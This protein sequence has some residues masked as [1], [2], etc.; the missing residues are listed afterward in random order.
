[1]AH[2]PII[3]IID[4]SIGSHKITNTIA[5]KD[6]VGD[7]LIAEGSHIGR[8]FFKNCYAT[9]IN[10]WEDLTTIPVAATTAQ[11]TYKDPHSNKTKTGPLEEVIEM[12]TTPPDPIINTLEAIK[13]RNWSGRI[14]DYSALE[15]AALMLEHASALISDS[16]RRKNLE[17]IAKI[18][19]DWLKH[20]NPNSNPTEAVRNAAQYA[21]DNTTNQSALEY[22]GATITLISEIVTLVTNSEPVTYQLRSLAACAINFIIDHANN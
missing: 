16:M 21:R 15:L 7:Y 12:L 3:Q 9:T 5:V 19:L 4:A 18:C 6:H 11:L 17:C 2:R 8:Y 22:Y 14:A 13:N 1:M 10:N 20:S